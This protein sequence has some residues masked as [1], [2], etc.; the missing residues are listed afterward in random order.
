[1]EKPSSLKNTYRWCSNIKKSK[2]IQYLTAKYFI[3]RAFTSI[4]N[5]DTQDSDSS[6]ITMK[7]LQG[8][9]MPVET[10]REHDVGLLLLWCHI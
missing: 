8:K 6:Y 1:M 5:I 7:V 3:D 10:S 9:E 4:K 2:H